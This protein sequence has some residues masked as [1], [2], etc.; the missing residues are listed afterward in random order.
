MNFIYNTG[1]R[2]HYYKKS[3]NG[4]CVARAISIATKTDYKEVWE[5]LCDIGKS[6]GQFSNSNIVWQMYLQ[7]RGWHKNSLGK[8]MPQISALKLKR[9]IVDCKV[10]YG[11]HLC[12]VVDGDL[13]DLWDCRDRLAYSYWEAQE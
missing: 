7:N 6:L 10:G 2:E 11:S 5:E 1:G 4:D 9:A 3:K 13:N 12:A 8:P